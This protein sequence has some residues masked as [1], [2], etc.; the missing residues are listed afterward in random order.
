MSGRPLLAPGSDDEALTAS[1]FAPVWRPASRGYKRL[2]GFGLAG[3]ALLGVGLVQLGRVGLSSLSDGGNVAWGVDAVSFTWWVGLA[4]AGTMLS[5]GL[6]LFEQPWRSGI[7]RAAEAM[8]LFAGGCAVLCGVASTGRPGLDHWLLPFP[9]AAG[10]GPQLDSPLSW[11]APALISWGAVSLLFGYL[12]LLPDL[13]TLRDRSPTRAARLCYGVL[14]LGWRGSGRH[15]AHWKL[16]YLLLGG[17]CTALSLGGQAVVAFAF[18]TS[19]LTGWHS[20]LLPVCFVAGALCSGAAML[21]LLLLPASRLLGL[22]HVITD[23]HFDALNRL[24]LATSLVLLYGRAVE[25]FIAWYSGEP[26]ADA[27]FFHARLAGP[28]APVCWTMLLCACGVPQL[29]WFERARASARVTLAVSLLV[30]VGVWLDRFVSVVVS[31]HHDLVASSWTVY[32]PTWVDACLLLGSL[33][34]FLTSMLLFFKLMPGV[35]ASGVKELK[36]ELAA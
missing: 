33:S 27:L 20:T 34:F 16:S 17:L 14:A 8:A 9:S 26:D 10:L 30:S 12:G 13:A 4:Q 22:G 6:L 28:Y 3:T 29:Y 36:E 31:L 25:A 23:R 1:L 24:V 5:A 2:L 21:A 18:A 35:A 11:S 15:W 7:H 32:L 19:Q